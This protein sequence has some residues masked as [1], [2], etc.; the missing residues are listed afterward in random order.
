MIGYMVKMRLSTWIKLKYRVVNFHRHDEFAFSM[1]MKCVN[2]IVK[3][4]NNKNK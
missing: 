3:H 4:I 2:K 1:N